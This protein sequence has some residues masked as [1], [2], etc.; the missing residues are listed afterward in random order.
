MWMARLAPS[1][2]DIMFFTLL[3]QFAKQA[4]ILPRRICGRMVL[5]AGIRAYVDPRGRRKRRTAL[6]LYKG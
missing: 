2:I 1:V 6:A 4:A 3:E 5:A